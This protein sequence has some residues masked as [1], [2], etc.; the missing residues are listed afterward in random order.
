MHR[1]ETDL[2]DSQNSRDV[3]LVLGA[4]CIGQAI[5]INNGVMHPAGLGWLALAIISLLIAIIPSINNRF[6]ILQKLNLSAV[7]I[8]CIFIELLE[9]IFWQLHWEKSPAITSGFLCISG[10][11]VLLAISRPALAH[12]GMLLIVLGHFAAGLLTI[13]SSPKPY[14]DVFY[15]Q[16]ESTAALLHGNDPYAVKFRDI[17]G[18]TDEPAYLPNMVVNRRLIF[19]YPYPPL[20]LLTTAAGEIFGDVRFAHLVAL[21]LSAILI[22]A[23]MRL[24]LRSI[25]AAAMLLLSAR[26]LLVIEVG[27]TEPMV[28]LMVCAVIY[29]ACRAPRWLWLTFGLLLHGFKQGRVRVLVATDIAARGID[30]D[31]ITH[32]INFELPNE[33]ESYV[34]RI[35]RTAPGGRHRH[36][37]LLL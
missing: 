19:S 14:I 28:L 7:L 26:S 4:F 27:W 29:S 15:F 9:L 35:G 12:W 18:G 1:H 32:V 22:A 10:C 8:A 20:M 6:V 25:L 37:H 34:H 30:V 17:M 24:T 3:L 16:D 21:E 2:S 23:A 13:A 31:G 36:R 5:Q 11:G 33:P